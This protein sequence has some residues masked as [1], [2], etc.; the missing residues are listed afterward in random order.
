MALPVATLLSIVLLSCKSQPVPIA[1]GVYV[2]ISSFSDDVL[3]ITRELPVNGKLGKAQV[4]PL[5][6]KSALDNVLEQFEEYK[7]TNNYGTALYYAF[8]KAL[9][10]IDNAI[11]TGA[12][13]KDIETITIFTITD[14]VDNGSANPLLRDFSSQNK[15]LVLPR[16]KRL[17]GGYD[18]FLKSI[19]RRGIKDRPVQSYVYNLGTG[20]YKELA[21]IVTD[22]ANVISTNSADLQKELMRIP[23]KIN[24]VNNSSQIVLVLPSYTNNTP[25][26]I[27]IADNAVQLTLKGIIKFSNKGTMLAITEQTGTAGINLENGPN[28]PAQIGDGG[29]GYRFV[30]NHKFSLSNTKVTTMR[31]DVK[32]TEMY[33]NIA[34]GSF[35]RRNSALVYFLIDS[36]V[37]INNKYKEI[38]TAVTDSIKKLYEGSVTNP[39]VES[40][41]SLDSLSKNSTPQKDVMQGGPHIISYLIAVLNKNDPQILSQILNPQSTPGYID[42]DWWS[43]SAS[44]A[45]S[46][47]AASSADSNQSWEFKMNTPDARVFKLSISRDKEEP[48]KTKQDYNNFLHVQEDAFKII[49]D[50][51]APN[52]A[53]QNEIT[54]W[55]RISQ[56]SNL[57]NAINDFLILTDNGFQNACVIKRKA[58]NGSP[59]YEVRLG[60]YS[61][62]AASTA[63]ARLRP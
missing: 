51:N 56:S 29:F 45:S 33:F 63:K 36:S 15:A 28:I 3:D 61:Q 26:E 49:T 58:K 44:A 42:A 2:G 14:G 60:P 57:K 9:I 40:D 20:D 5:S 52:T 22:Y 17:A 53:N 10:N 34:P 30:I 32:E 39:Q 21:N 19:L 11:K 1:H 27:L 43:I 4:V 8:N 38:K 62:E 50:L 48:K 13:P 37:S 6:Y 47:A 54:H 41:A 16:S 55:I 46:A 25:I 31:N 59:Y 7:P 24:S 35:M 12:V 23:E 18:S